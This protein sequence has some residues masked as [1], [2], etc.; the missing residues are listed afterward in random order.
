MVKI[1]E[2]KVHKWDI[3]EVLRDVATRGQTF[4]CRKFYFEENGLTWSSEN[5]RL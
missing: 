5:G 3:T 4:D 2:F 1:L